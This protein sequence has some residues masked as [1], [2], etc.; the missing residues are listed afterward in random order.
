MPVPSIF[1]KP[2]RKRIQFCIVK[3]QID[4]NAT[5]LLAIQLTNNSFGYV[6]GAAVGLVLAS[7]LVYSLIKY[8][9]F[10]L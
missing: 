3:K 10:K 6:I 8:Q 5:I 1:I 2:L 9:K 7:Y 4:M